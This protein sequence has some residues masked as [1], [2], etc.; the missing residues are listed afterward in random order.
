MA[1]LSMADQATSSAPRHS[2]KH[3]IA[4]DS[5]NLILE[6]VKMPLPLNAL[7]SGFKLGCAI[8]LS[9][10]LGCSRVLPVCDVR[11]ASLI[12]IEAL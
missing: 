9:V 7:L 1:W 8:A 11:R 2:H 4:H 12:R 5:F 6:A 3:S 10:L